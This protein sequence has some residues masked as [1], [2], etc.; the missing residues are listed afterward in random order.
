MAQELI[1]NKTVAIIGGGPAGCA[2]AKFLSDY[3]L[4]VSLF[5]KDMFLKTLLPTGGGKCNLAHNEFDIKNLASNYPR[6]EKFLYSIFSQFSTQDTLDFFKSI[7]VETYCRKDGKIFPVSN[8]SSDVRKKLLDSLK[9]RFIKEKVEKI[10]FCNNFYKIKSNKS[11]YAFDNVV[12]AIGGHSSVDLL[13]DLD[14]KIVEQ[15]PS[16]VGLVTSQ[17]LSELS[18]VSIKNIQAKIDNKTYFGDVLFT[19]KGVSGPLIYTISSIYARGNLPYKIHFSFV[20]DLNLQQYLDKNSKKEI[21]NVLCSF[22]PKSL[23][24]YILKDLDIAAEL[25]CHKIDGKTRDKIVQKLVNFELDIIGHVADSEVVT[26]GGID[27]KEV[28]PKTLESKKY[29]GLYFCGEILDIDGFCGGFNLQNCWSSG[30]VTAFGIS[31]QT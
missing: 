16:L 22:V 24:I 5:D 30:Y 2:C 3:G 1:S 14:I 17:D 26:C 23:A 9:C 13:S 7:G 4:D 20:K 18:G 19:H 6:G 28:N 8:S 31:C 11:E 10:E 21:K 29:K 25:L 15:K 12:V 27:L